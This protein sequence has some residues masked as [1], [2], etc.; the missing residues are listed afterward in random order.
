MTD[1]LTGS[2]THLD[3]AAKCLE[4]PMKPGGGKASTKSGPNTLMLE[5]LNTDVVYIQ[6]LG[7]RMPDPDVAGTGAG[8]GGVAPHP[9]HAVLQAPE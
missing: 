2:V 7:Q 1:G 8:G 5:C 4:Q 9:V 3:R 6:K